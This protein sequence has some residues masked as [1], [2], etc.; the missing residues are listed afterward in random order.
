MNLSNSK[1]LDSFIDNQSSLKDALSRT[2]EG[3]TSFN[4]EF[5]MEE[6]SSGQSSFDQEETSNQNRALHS[7]SQIL[8]SSENNKNIGEDLNYL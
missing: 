7:S 5:N 8:E 4:L 1:T 6:N 3:Q 2:F